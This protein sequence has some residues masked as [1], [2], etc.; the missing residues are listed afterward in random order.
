V[1]RSM[2]ISRENNPRNA[3]IGL[4]T[5]VSYTQTTAPADKIL[6]HRG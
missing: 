4:I 6:Q 3:S 2:P 1:P 5:S